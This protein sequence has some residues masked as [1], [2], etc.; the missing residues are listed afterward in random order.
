[1][2]KIITFILL[3]SFI[4]PVFSQNL[5]KKFIKG[6]IAD[7]IDAVRQA[8]GEEGIWITKKSLDFILDNKEL[9][10]NDRELNG[11]AVATVLSISFD[12]INTLYDNEKNELVDK[13]INIF[14]SFS[15][16]DTVQIAILSKIIG[17]SNLNL[18]NTN[19]FTFLLNDYL[20]NTSIDE[21]NS[22]VYKSVVAA[23]SNIGN[24]V[25][26]TIL[27]N[28]L[29]DKDYTQFKNEI[30]K[31]IIELSPIAI[32]EV[33]QIVHC[34]D[35]YQISQILSLIQKNS[36]NSQNFLSEIAENVLNE[37]ILL[38]GNSSEN[39]D[40]IIGLQIYSLNILNENKWTRA[41]DSVI[42]FFD[43]AKF[44]YTNNLMSEE[45]FAIVIQSLAN[46]APINSVT[47]LIK[48]LGEL[49]GQVERENYV[50]QNIVLAVINTLG[51]IGDKSAF[52][53]L[54]SV[55]Y[56]DYSES[57]LSAARKALAGLKW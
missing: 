40:D 19:R 29:N 22:D 13:L 38:I 9:L 8:S 31:S 25:S 6:S 24:N 33:L 36:K 5:Q 17:L 47:P 55:T 56:L 32:N 48:Y 41:A 27:Y 18:I 21:I 28:Q 53:S 43:T 12:Y 11:L 1:M 10:D 3:I 57:V 54:L 49:N 52:D 44:E 7:K 14:S 2:K 34:K 51:A 39:I 50:S 4:I 37:T 46:I 23:L 26:F 16:S 45:Q 42:S 15:E 35:V 20:Q 30:E